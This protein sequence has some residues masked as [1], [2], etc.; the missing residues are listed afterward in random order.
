[1]H[2]L[3]GDQEFTGMESFCMDLVIT[4]NLSIAES[5]A[6]SSTTLLRYIDQRNEYRRYLKWKVKI[7]YDFFTFIDVEFYAAYLSFDYENT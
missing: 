4:C 7:W 5:I 3:A 2:V 6:L 1:M